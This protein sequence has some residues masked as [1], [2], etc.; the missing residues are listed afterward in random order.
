MIKNNKGK[1]LI[2]SLL[3]LCPILVGVLLWNDLPQTIAVHWGVDGS[4][5]GWAG[6]GVMVFVLPLILLALH[7]LCMV[8]TGK[9]PKQQGQN[10]KAIGMIFWIMPVVSWFASGLMYGAAFGLSLNAIRLL[11]VLIGVL[12]M[13]IGNYMPKCKQNYTLGIKIYWTLRDEETWNKTHRLAGKVWFVGGVLIL[14]AALIPGLLAPLY[15]VLILLIPMVVIP[16]IYAYTVYNKRRAAGLLSP[17]DATYFPNKKIK[18]I[19]L[20]SI[21]VILLAV[22]VIMFT[23]EV[24]VTYGENSFTVDSTYWSALTVEYDAIDTLEY[25]ESHPEGIRLN[26]FASG[27]LL[28]GIFEDEDCGQYTRYTYSRCKESVLLLVDGKILRVNGTD[29]AAT[30]AIYDTLLERIEK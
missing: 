26:G 3:I 9:D 14:F 19:S 27:T 15:G 8:V 1:A 5:D 20:I 17:V 29:E 25:Q 23:G 30:K 22:A 10:R 11:P 24:T 12:F 28:L 21:T 6:R 13:V 18:I 7:W 2:S 16:Y 4:A